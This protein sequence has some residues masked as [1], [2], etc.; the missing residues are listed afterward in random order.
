VTDFNPD[1]SAPCVDNETVLA[2]V[3]ELADWLRANRIV[4]VVAPSQVDRLR[5]YVQALPI[6]CAPGLIEIRSSP[7]MPADCLIVV[8]NGPIEPVRPWPLRPPIDP[9]ELLGQYH[10]IP[11]AHVMVTP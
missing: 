4:F 6:E 10:P 3:R 2:R 1:P 11:F 8:R 5:S 7:G 9:N